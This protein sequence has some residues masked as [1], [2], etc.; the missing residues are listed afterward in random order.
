MFV[1]R[2]Y[3]TYH[4]SDESGTYEYGTFSTPELASARV[5]T[6]WA[7]KRYPKTFEVTELGGRF[8]TLGYSDY[9]QIHVSKITVDEEI[10]DDHCGYT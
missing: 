10:N 2:V 6:M 8:S 3:E 5:A 1:Y 9:T 4:Y 7:F